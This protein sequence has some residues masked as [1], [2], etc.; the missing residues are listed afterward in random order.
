WTSLGYRQEYWDKKGKRHLHKVK[1]EECFFTED[2]IQFKIYV[3]HLIV[4]G[5]TIHHLPDQ[6]RAWDL[7]KAETL[8]E[9]TAACERKV[10]S[11]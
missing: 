1:I 11:P 9:L 4:L 2:E 7:V 3:S 10:T 8:R 6:V 5:S